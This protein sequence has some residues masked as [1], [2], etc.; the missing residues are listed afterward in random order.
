VLETFVQP[1]PFY[2]G[3]DVAVLTPLANMTLPEKLWWVAAIRANRYRYNY[4]R[5]ANRTLADL[6]LPDVAPAF[7]ATTSVPDFSSL[8]AAAGPA[9]ATEVEIPDFST[10]RD[11]AHAGEVPFDTS[12]WQSF[13]YE[14]L[15]DFAHG[16]RLTKEELKPGSTPFLRSTERNNGLVFMADLPAAHPAGVITVSYNG[17]VGESFYQPAPFFASDDVFVL[18]RRH[19]CRLLPH[20]SCVP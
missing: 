10:L 14:D 16:E 11:P 13:R 15:F 18:T 7:V 6:D 17:S 20:C 9:G 2:C 4:G 3:R 1:S 8:R 19:R 5:Q 12:R